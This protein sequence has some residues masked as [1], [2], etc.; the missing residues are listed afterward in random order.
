MK[1]KRS[2][3]S[4]KE[5]LIVSEKAQLMSD[6]REAVEELKLIHQGKLKGIPA[7]ELLNLL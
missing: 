2:Q 6:I 5:K 1:T 7:N 4:T 3:I